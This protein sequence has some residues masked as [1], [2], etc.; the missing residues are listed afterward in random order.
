MLED[1]LGLPYLVSLSNFVEI[2]RIVLLATVDYS[3]DNGDEISEREV[4]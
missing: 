4:I 1:D 3:M 2:R